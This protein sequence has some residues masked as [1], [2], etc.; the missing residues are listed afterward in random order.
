MLACGERAGAQSQ[1]ETLCLSDDDCSWGLVCG[2]DARCVRDASALRSA[3]AGFDAGETQRRWT[4]WG[5]TTQL[6]MATMSMESAVCTAQDIRLDDLDGYLDD[7]VPESGDVHGPLSDVSGRCGD[8]L[9][10]TAWRLSNCER[11]AR[12]MEPLQCDMRLVWAGREHSLDMT[13]RSYFS[14]ESPEGLT[15]VERLDAQDIGFLFAGENLAHYTD[16]IGAHRGWMESEEHRRNILNDR[17]THAGVGAVEA[18]DDRVYAVQLF[19]R[20]Q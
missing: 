17:Y 4:E 15:N 10:T 5:T 6:P 12:G 20:P 19:I 9:E 16:I 8:D 2:Q 18:E 11:M 7:Y 3:D 13:G 1:S 14:H